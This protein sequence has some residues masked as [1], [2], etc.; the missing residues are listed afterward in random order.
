MSEKP[1]PVVLSVARTCVPP[2][3]QAACCLRHE[4]F[5]STVHGV[6]PDGQATCQSSLD[7]LLCLDMQPPTGQ[8]TA[9]QLAAT[10]RTIWSMKE[11]GSRLLRLPSAVRPVGAVL[12]AR[13]R[14]VT[15]TDTV[16]RR[17][18]TFS[19]VQ[20]WHSLPVTCQ[21]G[22]PVCPLSSVHKCVQVIG[23]RGNPPAA[24]Q[25]GRR[26]SIQQQ[27]SQRACKQ[28][29]KSSIQDTATSQQNGPVRDAPDA[30]PGCSRSRARCFWMS[31]PRKSHSASCE[32]C[33][34]ASGSSGNLLAS[35]RTT[36][37][38]GAA[39]GS[40]STMDFAA[41]RPSRRAADRC[42]HRGAG[43]AAH[44]SVFLLLSALV[45]RRT[46]AELHNLWGQYQAQGLGRQR[47]GP[48]WW[49]LAGGSH[50]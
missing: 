48:G 18:H 15:R 17:L 3:Q 29:S 30:A 47:Q 41:G 40:A 31:L 36:G 46:A 2:A 39:S 23:R 4:P 10:Q 16:H 1:A 32:F 24:H 12:P 34:L 19:R 20:P 27:A 43:Q 35:Q 42:P 8:H 22:S 25:A 49:T 5:E 28:R 11:P 45:G 33:S 26:A 7:K 14:A 38:A 6:M 50:S 37:A 9:L 21:Q 44:V 13:E